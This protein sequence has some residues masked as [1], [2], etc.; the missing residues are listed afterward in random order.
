LLRLRAS[1]INQQAG[2]QS[3][4]QDFLSHFIFLSILHLQGDAAGKKPK[5]TMFSFV[6]ASASLRGHYFA[7]RK[8]YH[9]DRQQQVQMVPYAVKIARSVLRGG[10]CSSVRLLPANISLIL[11]R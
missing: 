9:T 5:S 6:E 11:A 3:A 2:L 4:R 1:A 8:S 10:T 7:T